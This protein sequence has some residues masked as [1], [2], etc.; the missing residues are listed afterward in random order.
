MVSKV[1]SINESYVDDFRDVVK[2]LE[3]IMESTFKMIKYI[4]DRSEFNEQ[5][6]EIELRKKMKVCMT[7]KDILGC[8]AQAFQYFKAEAWVLVLTNP[9]LLQYL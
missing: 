1:F 6:T 3:K 4:H 2:E 8:L 9:L 5:P 7:L